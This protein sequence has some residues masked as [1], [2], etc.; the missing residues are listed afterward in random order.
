MAK[1][2]SGYD[3]LIDKLDQFIRKYYVNRLIRGFLYSVGL[4]LA[5]FLVFTLLEHYF[6]FSKAVRKG[7]FF[8]FMLTSVFAL[9]Y[10][11]VFPLIHYLGLGKTISHEQ[12]AM[13]VGDHFSDV[14]DRLL[15]ILQL[16][17]ASDEN[18]HASL[19]AASIEQKT[20]AIKLVP[21]KSAIDLSLNR[22]YL[23]YAL[24]PFLLLLVILFAAPSLIKDSTKRI[25]NNDKDYE[26][27]APFSF[28]FEESNPKVLQF[29]DYKVVVNV[30]G[31][32]LPDE[33]YIE[34]DNFQYRLQ[35]ENPTT[36][37]YRLRNLQK[38]T[39]VRV[40]SGT[41]TSHELEI[42]VLEKP[43]LGTFQVAL[44]YPS[45]TGRKDETV[46]N[47]GNLSV[48][49]GTTAR[50]TISASNTDAVS[51]KF[52]NTLR[53]T[54][55]K[56][57]NEFSHKEYL[58]NSMLYKIYIDN[59]N[60]QKPDSIAYNISVQKDAFPKIDVEEFTDSLEQNVKYF[61]GN[62][63]DDYGLQEIKFVYQISDENGNNRPQQVNII[64]RPEARES[65]F[66]HSFDF[67][68]LSLKPGESVKYYY[69]VGDNDAVNGSKIA[70]SGVMS[71]EKPTEEEFKQQEEENSEQIKEDLKESIENMEK[72]K[73]QYEKMRQDLLQKN[74]LDWQDKEE[75][76]KLIDK[77]K[78]IQD[79]LE[80]AK[81]KFD[82]NLE[83]QQEFNEQ[84]EEIQDKQEKMQELFE[85]A[86]DPKK[87]ELLDKIESLLQELQ[88]ENSLE[89]MEQMEQ[90]ND[91][92]EMDMK[93]LLELY[94]QLE[95][96]QK[97][98]EVMEELEKLADEQEELAKETEEGKKSNEELQK[99]Q[100]ELNEKMEKLKEEME[101]LDK[102][103][104]DLQRPKELGEENEEQMDDIQEDQQESMEDL[105]KQDNKGA[106]KNQKQA[107]SKMRQMS[108]G[109]KSSMQGGD[110]DQQKE[111]AKLLRQILENLV[112][113]SFDQED[114][115]GEVNITSTI[116]PRY[117]DLVQ[118]QF[119]IK[120]DFKIVE[121]S[122]VALANRNDQIQSF[123]MDKVSEVKVNMKSSLKFLED[124]KKKD[125]TNNQRR[126]M[127]NTNDL[128]LMLSEAL[129]NMQQSMSQSMPGNQMCNKPGSNPGS[130][131][132]KVPSDKLSESSDGLGKKL[133]EMMG[134]QKGDGQGGGNTAKDFAEA[135]AR[136]ASMRKALEDM[137]RKAKEQ[138]QGSKELEQ[139]IEEMNK[140][141][142]DLV[143]KRLDGELLKRQQE[144]T[145]RLLK[146]EKAERKREYDNKR[147]AE[148]ATELPREFP[149]SLQEYLKKREAE[150]EMYKTVAPD[151]RQYY[152]SLV[153]EYYRALKN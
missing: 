135:A 62:A 133:K 13:I 120:D 123:V 26:R 10:W 74:D 21:F 116:A 15:N 42:D 52:A 1:K 87:Q 48:P 148:T 77:Q 58:K 118:Q 90:N 82:Q 67:D 73:E 6:Y 65:E 93:R 85:E 125:A 71:F 23:K 32:V 69:E 108:S 39:K 126:T 109:M 110:Q 45:Y 47:L 75:L 19:L 37:T 14:K 113:I 107:A 41:V 142:I 134:K 86:M 97:A 56:G 117:V 122:L 2:L 34:V 132:G 112:N 124:R 139:L 33:A 81:E 130:K 43:T 36:F 61:I 40:V 105:Q 128:A 44:D 60:I 49:E 57:A 83:N 101:K 63:A 131:P 72:I 144:I 53:K 12:A 59:Q 68:D 16:K 99:K 20:E 143:N 91:N 95:V 140:I 29:D 137:Q 28:L 25:I 22:K 78:E 70:R 38:D 96:E 66:S 5:L 149:P 153:D 11:V 98:Q 114:I 27:A 31:D 24:P 103:N 35:K 104:E 80:N 147:K 94:K 79:K 102:M 76:Q 141:E 136:Q 84:N 121:D 151:L 4:I 119:K 30:E 138:G 92:S 146:A 115:S 106:A 100:E 150:V 51:M 64:K 8:S 18:V 9:A 50:W 46:K 152:K 55:K 129:A 3:L 89:M 88:K 17:K 111:D 54:D 145:T 7:I 127:T